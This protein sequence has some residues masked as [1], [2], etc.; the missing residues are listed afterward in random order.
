MTTVGTGGDRAMALLTT[1]TTLEKHSKAAA[2]VAAVSPR[3]MKV[4]AEWRGG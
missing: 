2:E 4:M 1:V 3:E